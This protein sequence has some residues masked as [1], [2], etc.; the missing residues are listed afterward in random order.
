MAE[1]GYKKVEVGFVA[2][3][4]IQMRLSDGDYESLR[5]ALVNGDGTRWQELKA[6]D[7]DVTLDLS[8]VA[9]I[10]LDTERGRVGF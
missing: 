7:T 1:S 9:Y 4:V 6:E 8:K 5:G 3:G 2:G 10:R